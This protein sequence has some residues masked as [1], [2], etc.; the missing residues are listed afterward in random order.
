M[1]KLYLVFLMSLLSV[2]FDDMNA[3]KL[4]RQMYDRYHGKWYTSFTFVQ[5]TERYRHDSLIQ[6]ST[7][8]EALT[9]PDKFRIDF[10]QIKDGNAV[11]FRN[12]SIYD[13]RKGELKNKGID[14]N[15]L[16]FLLGGLY[17]FPIDK[18]LEEIKSL[19][20]DLGKFH[21]D[22]WKGRDVYVIGANTKEEKTNQLWIDKERL[23]LLRMIKY[24]EKTKEEGWFEDHI[25]I[26]GGWSET[27]AIF[28]INDQLLQ[29]EYYHD[30]K[31]NP[32]LDPGIFDP[33]AFGKIYWF[34]E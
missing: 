26:G 3:E 19:H 8:Y 30:C 18:V 6:K 21:E 24:D 28:Y 33:A 32:P 1:T 4:L 2:G 34:K 10:G 13:F 11:I 9:F 27:T 5:T 17:F 29:K 7:W 23:I 31:A 20:Y 14:K 25:Q 12:D 22:N 15:D 16:T